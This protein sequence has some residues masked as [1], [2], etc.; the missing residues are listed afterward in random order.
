MRLR[1]YF[2]CRVAV[3]PE[4]VNSRWDHAQFFAGLVEL[5]TARGAEHEAIMQARGDAPIPEDGLPYVPRV[6]CVAGHGQP[7]TLRG[8]FVPS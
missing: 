8:A 6:A 5:G 3:W 1:P 7:P 4:R 2:D